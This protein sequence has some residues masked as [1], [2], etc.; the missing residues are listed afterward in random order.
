[1]ALYS[2][3]PHCQG[4]IYIFLLNAAGCEAWQ[5]T[6]TTCRNGFLPIIDIPD[7]KIKKIG[8]LTEKTC[9]FYQETLFY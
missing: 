2:T 6:I 5:E 1:V 9:F 3:I 7:Q 8:N 4:E